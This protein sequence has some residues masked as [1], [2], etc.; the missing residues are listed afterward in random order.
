[1]RTI[2]HKGY[3][4]AY[5][6]TEVKFKLPNKQVHW[7]WKLVGA[8]IRVA[9]NINST[10]DGFKMIRVPEAYTFECNSYHLPLDKFV[11]DTKKEAEAWLK[12]LCDGRLD[13]SN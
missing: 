10:R 11:F 2:F 9:L 8:Q 6:A 13:G 12:L 4:W 3:A 1:M 7:K 5:W